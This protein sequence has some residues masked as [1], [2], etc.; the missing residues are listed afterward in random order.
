MHAIYPI[1]RMPVRVRDVDPPKLD[2]LA[3]H[4]DPTMTRAVIALARPPKDRL[5]N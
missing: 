3:A 4:N 1:Q 5:G 2:R